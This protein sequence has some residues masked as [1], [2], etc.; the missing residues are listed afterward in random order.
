MKQ[1]RQPIECRRRPVV[2]AAVL[3]ALALSAAGARAAEALI[4]VAA[5]F[6]QPMQRIAAGF[7]AATGH[8]LKLSI[9]ATGKFYAQIRSGAPFAVLLAAD[10]AT[11]RKLIAEGHAVPGS[12]FSYATGRLVLWSARP[13][14]VDDQ[15]AVLAG[16]HFEHLAIANPKV[17]PYGAAALEVLR[18]RGLDAALAGRLVTGE[19]VGQAFQFV[20]SGNA[21]LGFV[22]RSQITVPGQAAVGSHWL[23]PQALHAPIRQDA[24]LLRA[25]ESNPAAQA[26]L[27]YLRSPPARE[28]IAAFGYDP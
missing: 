7:T 6:A 20:A 4:A 26:L 10:A 19:S 25:G 8:T 15:G 22:A 1:Y 27:A 13:G 11:P 23:V 24:V 12:S 16:G 3:L 14:F 28:L 21:E 9:G 2:L 17:A 5:N 18:A